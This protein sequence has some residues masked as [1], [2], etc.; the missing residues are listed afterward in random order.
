MGFLTA[1]QNCEKIENFFDNESFEEL[2]QIKVRPKKR[3]FFQKKIF[4]KKMTPH[5]FDCLETV[6]KVNFEKSFLNKRLFSDGIQ[7]QRRHLNKL[8][9][10]VNK[11]QRKGKSTF[12]SRLKIDKTFFRIVKSSRL[13]KLRL[14]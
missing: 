12:F 6:S 9:I 3:F 8:G 4:K 11:N 1:I 13:I 5:F 7:S 2:K 10:N 14:G